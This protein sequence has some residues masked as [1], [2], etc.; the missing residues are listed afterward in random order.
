MVFDPRHLDQASM[1]ARCVQLLENSAP[2][3][4]AL[5]QRLPE[6]LALAHTN[7]AATRPRRGCVQNAESVAD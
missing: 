5:Q 2:I 4:S 1:H 7:F 6:V 3:K